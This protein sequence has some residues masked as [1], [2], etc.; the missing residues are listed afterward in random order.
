MPMPQRGPVLIW[1][2]RIA[3]VLI[4]AGLVVYLVLIDG[5]KGA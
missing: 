2:G 4:M 5:H 3:A 1:A